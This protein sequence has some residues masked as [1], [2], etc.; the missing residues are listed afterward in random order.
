M[1]THT[2]DELSIF[3]LSAPMDNNLATV[4]LACWLI[5]ELRRGMLDMR[6]IT[7]ARHPPAPR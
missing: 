7:E 4:N 6:G 5:T 2:F 3:S 1:S